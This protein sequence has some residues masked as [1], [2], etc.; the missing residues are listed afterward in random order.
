MARVVN[1][2]VRN[3]EYNGLSVRRPQEKGS[4]DQHPCWQCADTGLVK[5]N[6]VSD[7]VVLDELFLFPTTD[8]YN[9]G[10]CAL[11]FVPMDPAT[12]KI[13]QDLANQDDLENKSK[14]Y[15]Q[16]SIDLTILFL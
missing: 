4:K 6:K 5:S 15:T 11:H 9:F 14:S 8:Q 1:T 7:V 16:A 3:E 13:L 10:L 2:R 12:K